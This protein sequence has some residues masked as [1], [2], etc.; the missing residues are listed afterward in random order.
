LT[1]TYCS[2]F[3]PAISIPIIGL[4]RLP[5]RLC[6]AVVILCPALRPVCR[7]SKEHQISTLLCSFIPR[8]IERL[9]S[10]P[11]WIPPHLTGASHL[12]LGLKGPAAWSR[13]LAH[14]EGLERSKTIHEFFS[15]TSLRPCSQAWTRT[16]LLGNFV[17]S[18]CLRYLR[19][20]GNNSPFGVIYDA[21]PAVIVAYIP[22]I[23][24]RTNNTGQQ[25]TS[26]PR[27]SYLSCIVDSIPFTLV[28][29][30]PSDH[31]RDALTDSMSRLPP[32]HFRSTHPG[33]L[34]SG[35]VWRGLTRAQLWRLI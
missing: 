16:C 7:D 33:W 2:F 32:S 28:S 31:N 26:P 27:F 3:V 23:F 34:C 30:P 19:S 35:R 29:R 6:R 4:V 9:R 24:P 22:F 12:V 8:L 5:L 21:E 18:R 25:S 14:S 20:S 1:N 10:A 17:A 11:R 15:E 13:L